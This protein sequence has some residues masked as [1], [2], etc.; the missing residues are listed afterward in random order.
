MKR[1][2]I[3]K[4][5]ILGVIFFIQLAHATPV[6]LPVVFEEM[7][8]S[9]H[10]AQEEDTDDS[11]TK[12]TKKYTNLLVHNS[13]A[14]GTLFV[15][16]NETVG[17][18]LLVNGSET[19]V[20]DLTVDG[21]LVVN[22]STTFTG[23]SIV[24]MG[25]ETINGNLT[26]TG[27]TTTGSLISK[28]SI[29]GNS[30]NITT[31]ATICSLNVTCGANINNATFGN[32]V[33]TG[34]TT[35]GKLVATNATIT[36]ATINNLTVTSLVAATIVATNSIVTNTAIFAN[37]VPPYAPLTQAMAGTVDFFGDSITA[38]VYLL[39]S[40]RWTTLLC[41]YFGS[42]QANYGI[43]GS[44]VNDSVQQI[45]T[46]YPPGTNLTTFQA[47][48]INDIA[49]GSANDNIFDEFRRTTEA[50]TL[51]C[52]LPDS[53]KVNAR[54]AV[55]TGSWGNANILGNWGVVTSTTASTL[56]A[57][58]T[59]RF[60]C[61]SIPCVTNT[62]YWNIYVDGTPTTILQP[63]VH[64]SPATELGSNINN[65]VYVY[66]TGS[67]PN[68]IHSIMA[69]YHGASSAP[70]YIAWLGGFNINNPNCNTAFLVSTTLPDFISIDNLMPPQ[71]GS[72]A[73]RQCWTQIQ[74]SICRRLRKEYGLPVYFVDM[75][76][77][78]TYGMLIGDLIHPNPNGMQYMANRAIS[79]VLNG[80]FNYLT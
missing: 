21:N 20:G 13:L 32:I 72:E 30:L 45:F 12:A 38:G 3:Y 15:G 1:N 7:P 42:T 57:T 54:D 48:G 55:L 66:D 50:M 36:T 68:A 58:V 24:I 74:Q 11:A 78:W 71:L 31:T 25:N 51:F 16:G 4:T 52:C 10:P 43:G 62:V 59:G 47:Y 61:F 2:W 17:H 39:L 65:A 79:V 46:N 53:Q 33:V 18:N 60:I 64:N 9:L 22:G 37:Y 35:T 75:S 5:C 76:Y 23:T 49:Y 40:Q 56:T 34:T 19:I 26:V 41:N 6:T 70:G 77:P 73:R 69:Y 28:S 8:D 80:E 27:T 14:C 63:V 29:T 67:A 44:M